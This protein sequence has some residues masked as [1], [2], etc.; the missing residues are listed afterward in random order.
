MGVHRLRSKDALRRAVGDDAG[1]RYK[2]VLEIQ[3]SGFPEPPP[4]VPDSAAAD[5]ATPVEVEAVPLGQE[6]LKRPWT[7]CGKRRTHLPSQFRCRPRRPPPDPIGDAIS[8]TVQGDIGVVIGQAVCDARGTNGDAACRIEAEEP[9][10]GHTVDP[11]IGADIALVKCMRAGYGK[12][13]NAHPRH[14][15]GDEAYPACAIVEIRLDA[16]RKQIAKASRLHAPMHKEQVV[17]PHPDQGP[18]RRTGLIGNTE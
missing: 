3:E 1:G 2:L 4:R 5:A 18:S 15:E 16:G 8:L 9:D 7:G 13:Q 10:P 17:P 11:D 14:R 12:P 6:P